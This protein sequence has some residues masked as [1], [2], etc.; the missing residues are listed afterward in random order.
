M[1]WLELALR[2]ADLQRVMQQAEQYYAAE[3]PDGGRNEKRSL[4]QPSRLRG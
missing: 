1:L 3:K 4:K 2:D